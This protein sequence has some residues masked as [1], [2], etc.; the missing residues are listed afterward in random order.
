MVYEYEYDDE[1]QTIKIN[2]MHSIYESSIE[3]Y[4]V[5]MA[6]AIDKLL[7]VKRP[8]RILFSGSREVEYDFVES[9][10]LLE[11]ALALEK[12][13]NEKIVSLKN[14]SIEGCE[15][16]IR[17]RF[18]F[19]QRVVSDIRY[20]PIKAYRKLLREIRHTTA[21]EQKETDEWHKKCYVHYKENTLLPVKKNT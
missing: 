1:T 11:I 4:D 17:P 2:A 9:R 21:D 12:I 15:R 13:M 18:V 3:D 10:L 5:V 8:A 16:D 7:E 14:V 19:M 20:D 6:T